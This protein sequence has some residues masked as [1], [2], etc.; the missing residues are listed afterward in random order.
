MENKYKLLE[1]FHDKTISLNSGEIG[2]KRKDLEKL[3][4]ELLKYNIAVTFT[5]A[6]I[7]DQ[8]QVQRLIPIKNGEILVFNFKVTK[9]DNENWF[10]FVERCAKETLDKINFWDIDKNIRRDLKSDLVYILDFK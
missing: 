7:F 10:D 8:T 5:E 9:K 2:F 6:V 3:F 1:M 4:E